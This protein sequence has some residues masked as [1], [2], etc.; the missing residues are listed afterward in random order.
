[1]I[2]MNPNKGRVTTIVA[3][4]KAKRGLGGEASSAPDQAYEEYK[5]KPESDTMAAK[6]AAMDSFLVASE[7]KDSRAMVRALTTFLELCEGYEEEESG[8]DES[9]KKKDA[10][11]YSSP[12]YGSHTQD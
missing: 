3:S 10:P 4:I 2:M 9:G 11:A 5:E 7:K 6:M 12:Q 1:M 8:E